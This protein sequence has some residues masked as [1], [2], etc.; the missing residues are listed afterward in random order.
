MATVLFD[1]LSITALEYVTSSQQ[2]F[3]L[4]ILFFFRFLISIKNSYC[5]R[6]LDKKIKYSDDSD[7]CRYALKLVILLF[8]NLQ[9]RIMV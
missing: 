3:D 6:S 5:F 7:I 4:E 9:A 1:T 8:T 2:C